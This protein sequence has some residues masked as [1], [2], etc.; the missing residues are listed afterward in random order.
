MKSENQRLPNSRIGFLGG[1]YPGFKILKK[2]T[3]L[4]TERRVVLVVNK[5]LI[6][7]TS[8]H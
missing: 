1:L 3:A 2:K 8:G 7:N 6:S 5:L 4:G